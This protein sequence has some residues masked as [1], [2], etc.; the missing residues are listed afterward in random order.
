MS[1]A[2]NLSL[3]I[4]GVCNRKCLHCHNRVP[5]GDA[6]PRQHMTLDE[7]GDI[8]EKFRPLDQL[9]ISGGEPTLHPQFREIAVHAREWFGANTLTLV[10]NGFKLLDYRDVWERF[11]DIWVTDYA[12]DEHAQE[13]IAALAELGRVFRRV[14]SDHRPMVSNGNVGPCERK[15]IATYNAGRLWPCCVAPGLPGSTST[16]LMANWRD[17]LERLPLSCSVCPF[18]E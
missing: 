11:D 12:D 4:T 8:A 1:H 9:Y 6:L 15:D 5:I 13:S 3:L 14:T 18:A 17:E 7:L 16:P 10:S 2:A